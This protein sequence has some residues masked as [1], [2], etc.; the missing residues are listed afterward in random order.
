MKQIDGVTS[1]VAEFNDTHTHAEVIRAF[2]IAID[3]VTK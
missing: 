3:E 1:A 2:N